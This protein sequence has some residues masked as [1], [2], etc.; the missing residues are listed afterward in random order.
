MKV[1]DKMSEAIEMRNEYRM[2]EFTNILAQRQTSG[3]SVRAFCQEIG[4]G[5]QTYNYRL[6]KLRQQACR[7]PIL[8][9]VQLESPANPA[10]NIQIQ[11]H[12]A[13]IEV[14]DEAALKAVLCALQHL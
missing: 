2:A 6:R 13:V 10:S 7:G 3:L 4:M 9:E 5:E 14:S 12:G 8:Q 11:Y 1:V